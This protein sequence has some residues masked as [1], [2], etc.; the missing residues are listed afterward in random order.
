MSVMR[1]LAF[2]ACRT[3]V[4]AGL[5]VLLF[6]LALWATGTF[7]VREP[8]PFV[9]EEVRVRPLGERYMLAVSILR[10]RGEGPF[11]AVILNHG[12]AATAQGRRAE[13]PDFFM[14]TAA[15]FA[16]RGYAVFMPL[17]RGFGMTGGEFVE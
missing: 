16:Q 10:P 12:V 7:Q 14:H 2:L 8:S 11:G 6:G 9:H 17:R 15:A 1:S 5:T 4:R 13:S 3:D